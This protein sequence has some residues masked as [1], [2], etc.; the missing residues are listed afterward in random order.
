ME[1]VIDASSI[2]N[3]SNATALEL[4]AQLN[5]CRLWVSPLVVGECEPTCAGIIVALQGQGRL[6]FVP[7]AQISAET[8]LDLLD[9]HQLGEGET[10]CIAL[11]SLH[12]YDFCCDDYRAREVAAGL[13]GNDH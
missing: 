6:N 8:F 5:R 7:P 1:L 9:A 3:L 12:P 4:V 13:L 11:C 2:I 10:E